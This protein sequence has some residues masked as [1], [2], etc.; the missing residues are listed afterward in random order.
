MFYNPNL[1]TKS[2]LGYREM[3]ISNYQSQMFSL[4]DN[5]FYLMWK[6][7]SYSLEEEQRGGEVARAVS[8]VSDD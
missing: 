4:E 3:Q 2:Y 7:W 5:V 1:Y 8:M 6:P